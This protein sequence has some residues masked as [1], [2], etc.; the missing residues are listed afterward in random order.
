[1]AV[2]VGGSAWACSCCWDSAP[3]R[4][5][6]P[7]ERFGFR[8]RCDARRQE[9]RDEV[10]LPQLHKSALPGRQRFTRQR[11]TSG[12]DVP[13]A[14]VHGAQ[15]HL[16]PSGRRI[17]GVDR[18]ACGENRSRAGRRPRIV[19]VAGTSGRDHWGEQT[20]RWPCAYRLSKEPSA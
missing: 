20:R 2:G 13:L 10:R 8:I 17:D 12:R 15:G 1:V 3:S 18:R 11:T 6:A 16:T 9:F 7:V 4:P 14:A 19:R 5:P